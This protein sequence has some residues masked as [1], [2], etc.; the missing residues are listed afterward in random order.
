MSDKVSHK[1]LFY[2]YYVGLKFNVF[3]NFAEFS[4]AQKW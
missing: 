2:L 4:T 3:I 1:L